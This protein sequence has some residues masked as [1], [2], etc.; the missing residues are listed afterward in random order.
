MSAIQTADEALA[1]ELEAIAA[2]AAERVH[3]EARGDH[4]GAEQ[5]QARVARAA[6]A[7]IAAGAGLG[8]VADAERAG[9][10]RARDALGHEVLRRVKKIGQRRGEVER[11]YTEAIRLAGRIGL[12]HREIAGAA[13][14]AHSTVK[15]V[16][17]RSDEER[18]RANATDPDAA[19]HATGG[20]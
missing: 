1:P 2:A 12:A 5:A 16:L 3:A 19:P 9:Q 20:E 17:T 6:G 10:A 8:P 15:A 11:E 14:I 13:G 18:G 4:A 7:A